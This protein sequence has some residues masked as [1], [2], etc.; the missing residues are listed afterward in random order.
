MTTANGATDQIL[1]NLMTDM[2][3]AYYLAL[4]DGASVEQA[5]QKIRNVAKRAVKERT[6]PKRLFVYA[7]VFVKYVDPLDLIEKT[8]QTY[9]VDNEVD[10]EQQQPQE[11]LLA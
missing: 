5:V 4:S 2:Q 10:H 9:A 6:I 11:S 7:D 3:L 1:H 8:Y